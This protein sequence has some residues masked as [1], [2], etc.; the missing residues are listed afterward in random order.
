MYQTIILS[1]DSAASLASMVPEDFTVAFTGSSVGAASA[2]LAENA[3]DVVITTAVLEDGYGADVAGLFRKKARRPEFL[4]LCDYRELESAR[5]AVELGVD[6]FLLLPVRYDEF[7]YALASIKLLLDKRNISRLHHITS[8]NFEQFAPILREQFFAEI[9]SGSPASREDISEQLDRLK[10]PPAAVDSP[11]A[12]VDVHIIEYDSYLLSKWKYGK[13]TL[14]TAV[15]N[16]LDDNDGFAC[17]FV[18]R[19][20]ADMTFVL[21]ALENSK[22]AEVE[23]LI[24]EQIRRHTAQAFEL[25]DMQLFM[26]LR[27]VFPTLPDMAQAMQQIKNEPEPEDTEIAH[28]PSQDFSGKLRVLITAVKMRQT[29]QACAVADSLVDELV[30]YGIGGT[31]HFLHNTACLVCDA[32][33]DDGVSKQ[34]Q[35]AAQALLSCRD[36]QQLRDGMR[37]LIFDYVETVKK[38]ARRS[39]DLIISKAKQY[40]AEHCQNDISLNDVADYV[41]LTPVYLSRFFKQKTGENFSAYLVRIRMERAIGLFRQGGYK[42][43]EVARMVGY[44]NAKYFAKLFK[45]YTGFSP[46]EFSYAMLDKLAK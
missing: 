7:T 33:F 8:L 24:Y 23:Q 39:D 25:F 17:Q 43:Y 11:C 21:L 32:V 34:K 45:N 19:S 2:F 10:I 5:R 38:N 37:R 44:K 46:R 12:I 26:N 27:K 30:G 42:I 16:L 22:P 4:M 36:D 1:N 9:V 29:E 41:Y 35:Q 40:I 6:F 14:Y 20:G 3:V 31:A 13:E 15:K 18:S 28:N